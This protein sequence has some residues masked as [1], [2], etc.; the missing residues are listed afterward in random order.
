MR[1]TTI[2]LILVA[3]LLI[4][5]AFIAQPDYEMSYKKFVEAILDDR[6]SAVTIS[7]I[8]DQ[9]RVTMNSGRIYHVWLPKET[10]S[11]Y[12]SLL[13]FRS[14]PIKSSMNPFRDLIANYGVVVRR[15]VFWRLLEAP[16]SIQPKALRGLAGRRCSVG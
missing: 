3:V 14:V 8:G 7:T 9:A 2:A 13:I 12:K 16:D 1:K 10:E 15:S 6:V 11:S 4:G 5:A